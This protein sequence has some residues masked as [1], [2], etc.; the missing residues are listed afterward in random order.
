MAASTLHKRW[1]VTMP[2][3]V[4]RTV[5]RG[6]GCTLAEMKRMFPDAVHIEP[7]S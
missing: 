1:A 2:N 5:Y 3:G 4:R 6:L 7:L